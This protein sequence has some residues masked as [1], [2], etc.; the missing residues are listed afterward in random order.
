MKLLTHF[1]ISTVQPLE[2][3]NG[4][5]ISSHT[6]LCLWLLIHAGIKCDSERGPSGPGELFHW[7]CGS[8]AIVEYLWSYE[9]WWRH[10]METF[11][12]LLALCEGNS[13]VTGEFPSQM[14]VTRSFDVFFYL[15]LNKPLSKPSI[16]RWYETPSRPLC[17]HCNCISWVKFPV[18]HHRKHKRTWTVC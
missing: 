16:R 8:H 3:G 5:V 1:Q 10:K 13:P 17:H 7:H 14:P 9:A 4:F 6:L 15:S 18:S 2:F 11:S 12:V